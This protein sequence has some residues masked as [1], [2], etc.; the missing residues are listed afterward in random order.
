MG[1]L[2]KEAKFVH[3]AFKLHS[4]QRRRQL[5]RSGGAHVLNVKLWGCGN[6]M[7]LYFSVQLVEKLGGLSPPN[8]KSGR[9]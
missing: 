3:S 1:N 2:I 8:L 9:A 6:E 4:S 7:I 5:P